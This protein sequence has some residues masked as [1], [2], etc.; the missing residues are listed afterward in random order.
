MDAATSDTRRQRGLALA[1]SQAAKIRRDTGDIW[2]V[3]S[4]AGGH[5]GYSV[6]VAKQTCTCPDH[7]DRQAR[8]KHLW[9]VAYV[10]HEITDDTTS[11]ATSESS[12][13]KILRIEVDGHFHGSSDVPKPWVAQIDGVDAKYGLARTFVQR[14]NDYQDAHRACSGNMY[15][16]VAAFPLHEGQ[17]YEVS[18]LRG[19]PSKRYVAREF[20]TVNEGQICPIEAATALALAEIYDGPMISYVVPESTAVARVDRLG[21]PTVCG[22]VTGE[23]SD[24]RL[25]QLRVGAIH[26]VVGTERMLILVLPD[27]K[28]QCL[29]QKDALTR[30]LTQETIP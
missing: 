15:G 29:S 10:R 24:T 22:F 11:L 27:G 9:A 28:V 21:S 4:Q 25:Y 17:L 3:P 18:R 1:R 20:L 12:R 30:M 5:A 8:C 23:K 7:V 13:L 19:R 14:L 6:N 2:H 26:E 16:V